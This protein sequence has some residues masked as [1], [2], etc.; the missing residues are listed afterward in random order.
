[1]SDEHTGG[2]KSDVVVDFYC[3]DAEGNAC[4][5]CQAYADHPEWLDVDTYSVEGSG[6]GYGMACDRIRK[7]CYEKN[8]AAAERAFNN[9]S[10]EEQRALLNYWLGVG[11]P[12]RPIIRH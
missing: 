7:I 3:P 1:M 9:F 8:P 6:L 4:Q 12:P 2:P 5:A 10:L 11:G